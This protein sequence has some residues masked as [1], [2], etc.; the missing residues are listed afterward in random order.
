M[1]LDAFLA[2]SLGATR[3]EAR[4][5]VRAGRVVLHDANGSAYL[6]P[7]G[8]LDPGMRLAN[9][10]EWQV[11]LD[12]EPV[13]APGH[14]YL[15]LNKPAGYVCSHDEGDGLSVLR[16]APTIPGLRIV[17]RLDK[18]TTG[19]VLLSTDGAFV[20][21]ITAPARGCRKT[22]RVGLKHAVEDPAAWQAQIAQGVQLA[23]D[24]A[25]TAPA[26]ARF[27]SPDTLELVLQE[28]RYHQVKRMVGALG[29]RVASLQRVAIGG[30]HVDGLASG[31]CRSLTAAELAMLGY[32]VEAET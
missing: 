25:P 28:G 29:N 13:T 18:D 5:W 3:A 4:Q 26:T 9:T 12:G 1:R 21:F 14:H 22:Y 23:A 6:A 31:A 32:T 17:G 8:K 10:G 7:R 2:K 20:H 16:L 27:L 11:L 24:D 19:L 30:L 15:V